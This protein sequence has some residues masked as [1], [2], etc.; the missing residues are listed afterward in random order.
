MSAIHLSPQKA[1]ELIGQKATLAAQKL[2]EQPQSFSYRAIS[3][4][5]RVVTNYRALDTKPAHALLQEHPTSFIGVMN[6]PHK[7]FE[8]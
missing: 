3:A 5:Y 4:P 6:Q 8:D 1:R 2:L 7:K